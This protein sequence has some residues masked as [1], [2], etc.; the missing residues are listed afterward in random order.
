[1]ED[2]PH[3]I[4]NLGALG[5]GGVRLGRLST[6]VFVT[7]TIRESSGRQH[8]EV[9]FDLVV[10]MKLKKQ[11]WGHVERIKDVKRL[12]GGCECG[13]GSVKIQERIPCGGW[14]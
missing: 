10:C 7:R 11:E 4:R 1:M 5:V 8:W 6:C 3:P 9:A 2:K 13:A 14:Y 12:S